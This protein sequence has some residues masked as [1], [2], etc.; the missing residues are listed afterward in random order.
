MDRL[1]ASLNAVVHGQ[2]KDTKENYVTLEDVDDD[3]FARFA[4]PAAF[5]DKLRQIVRWANLGE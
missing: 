2:T 4:T 1:S 5:G 3:V